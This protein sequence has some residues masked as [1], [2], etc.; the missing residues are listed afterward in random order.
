MSTRSWWKA[1]CRLPLQWQT[2][3]ER[4]CCTKAQL[5]K[6]NLLQILTTEFRKS[7]VHPPAANRR[8]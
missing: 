7:S 8:R 5:A 2:R 1:W 3:C 6:S 4:S